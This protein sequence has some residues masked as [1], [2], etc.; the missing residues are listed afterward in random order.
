MCRMELY[1]MRSSIFIN[2]QENDPDDT[3]VDDSPGGTKMSEK[4]NVSIEETDLE[5]EAGQ[6]EDIRSQ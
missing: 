5:Q 1:A 4:R 3:D 2:R 6:E